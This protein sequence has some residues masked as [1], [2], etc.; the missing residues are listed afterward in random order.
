MAAGSMFN[1]W[2]KLTPANFGHA[3]FPP[4]LEEYYATRKGNPVLGLTQQLAFGPRVGLPETLTKAGIGENRPPTRLPAEMVGI[5][6]PQYSSSS[7]ALIETDRLGEKLGAPD[8]Y[9][10]NPYKDWTYGIQYYAIYQG[11]NPKTAVSPLIYPQAYRPE[12]WAQNTVDF[13]QV[14]RED[15]QDI[16]ELSMEYSCKDCDI[17]SASLGAPV[18]YQPR[19]STAPLPVQAPGETAINGGY[20]TREFGRNTRDYPPPINPI[21]YLQRKKLGLPNPPILPDYDDTLLEQLK[22]GFVFE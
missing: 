13:P 19:N 17:A 4:M 20:T 10:D 18:F 21:L 22:D 3:E 16:T 1:P 8:V 14:N 12:V 11:E 9:R 2:G 15:T 7:H 5:K 6:Y